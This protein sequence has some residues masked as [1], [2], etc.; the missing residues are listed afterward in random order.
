MIYGLSVLSC[1]LITYNQFPSEYIEKT[2]TSWDITD[3]NTTR[4]FRLV[5]L[6]NFYSWR[7]FEIA[8]HISLY[9]AEPAQQKIER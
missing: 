4:L 1:L 7:A 5:K 3:Y 8:K 9:F 2:M 6:F